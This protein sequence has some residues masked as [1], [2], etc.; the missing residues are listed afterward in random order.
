MKK[1]LLF[2]LVITMFVVTLSFASSTV[3]PPSVTASENSKAITTE[4]TQFGPVMSVE[5]SRID[6]LT[7]GAVEAL[8]TETAQVTSTTTVT[9]HFTGV[10]EIA[11]YTLTTIKPYLTNYS[12][13]KGLMVADEKTIIYKGAVFRDVC[14]LEVRL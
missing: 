2:L 13:K 7:S 3:G 5:L 11:G 14:L 9:S 12:P 4:A 1:T 6:Y 10:D 8:K